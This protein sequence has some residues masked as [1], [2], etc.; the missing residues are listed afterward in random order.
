MLVLLE[1]QNYYIPKLKKGLIKIIKKRG[2]QVALEF[3]LLVAIAFAVSIIFMYA[4]MGQAEE[5]NDEQEFIA[6]QDIS[7]KIQNELTIAAGAESGYERDFF[8]PDSIHTFN[9]NISIMNNT[10]MITTD[11]KQFIR[12]I[13]QIDGNIKLGWNRIC[14]TDGVIEVETGSCIYT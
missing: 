13:P 2:G 9:Y 4:L 3:V 10:L 14:L 12:I 11:N 1:Q 7:A 5:L 6:V 8:L